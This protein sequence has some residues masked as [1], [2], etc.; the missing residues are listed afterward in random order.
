MFL[1]DEKT[2]PMRKS[3]KQKE[4]HI[5]NKKTL[6]KIILIVVTYAFLIVKEFQLNKSP[7]I[8]RKQIAKLVEQLL[9]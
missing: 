5:A 2:L 4:T 7:Q 6:A 1:N 9:D 3:T 8:I